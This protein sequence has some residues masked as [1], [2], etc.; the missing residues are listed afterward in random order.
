[1]PPKLLHHFD[2]ETKKT[3]TVYTV[4]TDSVRRLRSV[5]PRL[6]RNCYVKK[7]VLEDRATKQKIS[8]DEL[9][10]TI[11]LPDNPSVMS[12]EFGEILSH[13]LLREGNGDIEGPLKW[14][15]KNDR[16]KPIHRTDVI[17]FRTTPSTPRPDDL[18]VSA[19]VKMKATRTAK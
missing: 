2:R 11:Y 9:L 5:M 7:S 19:E 17:L 6:L 3:H 1:M 12:G 16:N 13:Y 14:R 18:I 15:W 4:T 8:A 10:K